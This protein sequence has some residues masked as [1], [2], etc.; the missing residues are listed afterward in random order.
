MSGTDVARLLLGATVGGTMIAHAVRHGRTLKGTAG[1]FGSIGFRRPELEAAAVEVGAGAALAAGPGFA[2]TA[3]QLIAF[4]RRPRP[5]APAE[6][7]EA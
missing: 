7:M 3:V 1:W 4:Y 2:A 6:D 5:E